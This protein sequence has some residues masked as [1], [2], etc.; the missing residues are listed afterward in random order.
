MGS[1]SV[2]STG[3]QGTRA[4]TLTHAHGH[5]HTCHTHTWRSAVWL[6][7]SFSD[8]CAETSLLAVRVHVCTS[9][10]FIAWSL[11]SKPRSSLKRSWDNFL[12]G[13]RM[14]RPSCF[15]WATQDLTWR[16]RW[17]HVDS[18]QASRQLQGVRHNGA[19]AQ[20]SGSNT[21]LDL[22]RK[23]TCLNDFG[24]VVVFEWEY[25]IY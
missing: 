13:M 7:V 22:Q 14:I 19:T 11:W 16:F 1:C 6:K 12:L 23:A 9:G 17:S 21:H 8:L 4:G 24:G 5:M 25:H 3:H 2:T 15:H 20:G 18:F 10:S